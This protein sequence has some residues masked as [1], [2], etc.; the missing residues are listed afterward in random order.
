[1][2]GTPP[3]TSEHF[4]LPPLAR[5]A[6]A[7]HV[8]RCLLGLPDSQVDLDSGRMA[9][10]FYCLG[11][12]DLL[13]MLQDK[14]SQTDRES[15]KEW[16]WEQQTRG[17]YGSGF[18]PSPFMAS[19]MPSE[20]T[21]YTDYDTPHIIMTYTALLTLAILRDDFSRL[22]KQGILLLLKACQRKDGS[23]STI[24]GSGETDLRTLYCAFVISHL[25]NDWSGVD[26]NRALAFIA[27]CRSYEGGY[28]QSPYCEANGGT[29]YIAMAAIRLAPSNSN[30]LSLSEIRK[31]IDWAVHK[32]HRS[33]GF[34]GRTNKIA[35]ACY[36]FWIGASLKIL[37][38]GNLV[39][40]RSLALFLASCQ[41]KFGGIAK[42]P[43]EHPDPYHTYLSL[44]ALSMFPPPQ[45]DNDAN[46]STWA[47]E[48][49]DPLINAR[50]ETADWA[51]SHIAIQ[52]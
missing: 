52:G 7:G 21:R 4:Y 43:G 35:D 17:K 1:M 2:S 6:H 12:L 29:T 22:E 40:S 49:L 44:A 39:D 25:L 23:F 15:W 42:A 28:G 16:I 37:G 13:K 19:S 18:R 30:S 38:A 34:C 50:G 46:S 41:F 51:R 47:F 14:T 32:Q 45:Y 24:P 20:G 9:I 11:S 33:G 3:A 5:A 31:T 10:A 36:C 26:V 48:S 8:K 27:S